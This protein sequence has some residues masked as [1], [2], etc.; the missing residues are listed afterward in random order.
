VFLSYSEDNKKYAEMLEQKFQHEGVSCYMAGRYINSGE[1]FPR[2]IIKALANA[3]EMCVLCS[4]TSLKSM[5]VHT[6]WGAAWALG[7]HVVPILLEIDVKDLPERLRSKHALQYPDMDVY[8]S[9]VKERKVK[10]E[11]R[12]FEEIYG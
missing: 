5:W 11:L 12:R 1:D 3:R 7:K 8:L 10:A 9:Q 4:R 6:E 2:E